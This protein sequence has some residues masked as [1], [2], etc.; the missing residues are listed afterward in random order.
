MAQRIET[1]LIDDLDGTKAAET[2]GFGLDGIFYEIDLS[3]KSAASLRRAFAKY[4]DA[5]RRTGRSRPT[6]TR[7]PS[8]SRTIREWARANNVPV[9]GRGRIPAEVVEKFNKANR[10]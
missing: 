8:N 6:R 1:M 2:V 4:V 10:G 5:G 7:I 9:T 3:E